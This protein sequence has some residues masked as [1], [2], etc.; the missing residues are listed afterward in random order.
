M[1]NTGKKLTADQIN[2]IVAAIKT[3]ML[4]LQCGPTES[5]QQMVHRFALSAGLPEIVGYYGADLNTGE[6]VRS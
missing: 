4:A 5:A 2:S 6:I 1:T 3:P